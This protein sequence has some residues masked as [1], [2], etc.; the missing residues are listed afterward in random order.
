MAYRLKRAQISTHPAPPSVA[1]ILISSQKRPYREKQKVEISKNR[2]KFSPECP[3]GEKCESRKIAR[4]L[5]GMGREKIKNP[6]RG[7]SAPFF[8]PA[9]AGLLDALKF[10]T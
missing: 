9:Q 4:K 3:M 10:K 7:R 6:R 1:E 2:Q 8:L 5:V